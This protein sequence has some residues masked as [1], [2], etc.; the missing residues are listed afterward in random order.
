[1]FKIP[2]GLIFTAS[3]VVAL[4]ESSI[5]QNMAAVAKSVTG[6]QTQDAM[7]RNIAEQ[8]ACGFPNCR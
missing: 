6:N 2:M 4:N 1:M 3:V 8:R 7:V 5:I